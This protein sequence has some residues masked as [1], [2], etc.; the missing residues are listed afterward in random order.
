MIWCPSS[1]T[2]GSALS[3]LQIKSSFNVNP[4]CDHDSCLVLRKR[5]G[6][7]QS[8]TSPKRV[9]VCVQICVSVGS[10]F[11]RAFTN[12]SLKKGRGG[13]G[14]Y[15]VSPISSRF[16][17]LKRLENLLMYKKWWYLLFLSLTSHEG[18]APAC[19]LISRMANLFDSSLRWGQG[20][21]F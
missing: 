20:D 10:V 19:S 15:L 5:S 1:S 4:L 13:G 2:P 8:I 21:M 14:G 17:F 16:L 9:T 6:N 18:S 7:L 3:C 12:I 11:L